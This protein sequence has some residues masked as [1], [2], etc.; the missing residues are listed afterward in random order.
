MQHWS[1]HA[2]LGIAGLLGSA[3][4]VALCSHAYAQSQAVGEATRLEEVVVTARRVEENIQKVPLAVT[5]LS[6]EAVKQ[7]GIVT[8]TDIMFA[9]PSVQMTTSFGRLTGGFS[10]RGLS[11][12]V[13]TYFAEVPGGPTESQAP[14]YDIS[15]VQVLNGP[16]GTLFGRANTAGAVLIEPTKP[17]LGEFSGSIEGTVGNLGMKRGTAV[18]NLPVVDDR[19][20]IRIAAHVDHLDGYVHVIGTDQRLSEDNSQE[21]R[22][23]VLWKPFGNK[24]TNYALAD[25]YNVNQASSGASV[26]AIDTNL[27]IQNLPASIDAPNGL[28]A[29]TATFGGVCS[30]AVANGLSPSVNACIDQ[31]LR[32]A[33][34]L[35]PALI[36]EYNRIQAGG[37]DAVRYTPA[38]PLLP[39]QERLRKLT[40]VDQ[41]QLDFGRVGPTTLSLR[42]IFSFQEAK[43]VTGW[44]VDGLGGLIQSSV[45]VPQTASYAFTVSGQQSGH[46]PILSEGPYQKLYTNETQLRGVVGEDLLS[47]NLGTY[48]QR[49]P[50]VINLEGIRN[51]SRVNSGLTL[52][53]QGYN[54]SFP[55]S[56]GGS[57]TQSAVFGQ[58]TVDLSHF[59]PFIEALHLTGGLRKS[60]DKSTVT[61]AR[62]TTDVATGHYVPGDAFTNT[63]KS[64]GYNSTLSLDAQVTDK[65]LVY[66]ATRKGYRPGG[67]N[68]VLN[69]AG[70][71]NFTPT[72]AP[73]TVQ[74]YELGAKWDVALGDARARLNVA[75]YRTDYNNIQRTFS[76]SVAGVTT[77]YIVNASAAQIQGAE[78]QGLLVWGP[79]DITG[80]YAYSDPKFTN[81]VGADPLGLI[82]PG[83]PACLAQSTAALCLINLADT[84]FPNIS[85][86]QG[87]VNVRYHVPLDDKWGNVILQGTWYA[88]SRRYFTD[89]AARNLQVFG[90][91]VLDALSQKAFQRIN[92]RADWTHIHGSGFS[93][94]LFVNNLTDAVYAL[95][96]VTQLHSLGTGTVIYAEPRTFGLELHYE[97]GG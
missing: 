39:Q 6:G 51:L 43:G 97:F 15:S 41:A 76:A 87:D 54:P 60:W 37:H 78:L 27:P 84:P 66:A 22:V 67:L 16:Q 55:F 26:G 32:A 29:G 3:A 49:A 63:T 57:T 93:A 52:A 94:A 85:K 38:D 80:N 48:Y 88:Q 5:A 45:S 96:T 95:T 62:V 64:E 2:R 90:P 34:T 17:K 30:V 11:G 73:E 72:Y 36:A 13:Q 8:T 18:I 59:A 56:D 79:W 86:H 89:A 40:F 24:F 14:L 23:S 7:Q 28:T 4:A 75:L 82:R 77:T 42:N 1:P 83:N 19:L 68:L 81:W 65:L 33:A 44:D 20:A 70:L 50:G 46:T 21:A 61:S 35:K 74:D 58:A 47:W 92:L 69:S 12:G 53:T 9:A 31:R 25:Y 91:Q 71:P 10:I